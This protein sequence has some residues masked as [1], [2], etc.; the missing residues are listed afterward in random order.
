MVIEEDLLGYLKEWEDSV[1]ACEGLSAA[2]KAVRLISRESRERLYMTVQ[3]LVGVT[4]YLLSLPN[5]HGHYLLSEHFSQDPVENY[6]GQLRARGSYNYCSNPTVQSCLTSM[7]FDRV[8]GSLAMLPLRGNSS[9]KKLLFTEEVID[10]TPL[11][12]RPRRK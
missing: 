4:R 5:I 11:V 2:Q 6:F 8:Q 10:D 1:N 12:K 3:S 9:R 7:Q